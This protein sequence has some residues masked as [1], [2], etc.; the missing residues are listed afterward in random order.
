[1]V[2]PAIGRYPSLKPEYVPN[3]ADFSWSVMGRRAT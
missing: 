3:A 2:A 1:M